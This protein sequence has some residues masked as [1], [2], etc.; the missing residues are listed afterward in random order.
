M[1]FDFLFGVFC[2]IWIL[3][4]GT[5]LLARIV[6]GAKRL[7]ALKEAQA[8]ER[9][10]AE[11]ID[12]LT[13]SKQITVQDLEAEATKRMIEVAEAQQK[14]AEL[15]KRPAP[16]ITI[17]GREP[18]RPSENLWVCSHDDPSNPLP[19]PRFMAAWAEDGA[20]AKAKIVAAF[21]GLNAPPLG[22]PM[23]LHEMQ[24]EM[25]RTK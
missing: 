20:H 18:P 12:E 22:R 19:V 9:K 23:M 1:D 13:E 21:G 8:S 6:Q 25:F 15:V 5:I 16:I 3:F 7:E 4:G 11:L 14:M 2:G 17:A 10:T 24:T